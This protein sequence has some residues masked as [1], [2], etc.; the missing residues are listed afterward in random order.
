MC[1]S[2]IF[3]TL[4][5]S[6]SWHIYRSSCRRCSI[7][8]GVLKN[9]QSLFLNKVSLFLIKSLF[10]FI[11]KEALVQVFPVNF[12][13]FLRTRFLQNT[14]GRLLLYLEPKIYSELCQGVFRTLCNTRILRTLSY[15]E[16]C[17]IENFGTYWE[18]WQI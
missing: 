16:L 18:F 6:E 17:H 8:K 5:H 1:N 7:K 13:K 15:T 11:K 2:C 9:C 3:R 4:P 14:S 12:A 10:F